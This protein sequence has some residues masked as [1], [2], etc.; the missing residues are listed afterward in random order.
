LPPLKIT[1]P[2]PGGLSY[3]SWLRTPS[4][5]Q[6]VEFIENRIVPTQDMLAFQGRW[7]YFN[8]AVAIPQNDFWQFTAVCPPDE[9]WRI[10]HI[11]VEFTTDANL[12]CSILIQSNF[13][14]AANSLTRVAFHEVENGSQQ[15]LYPTWNELST[16]A[17]NDTYNYIG[18]N[19]IILPN[20]SLI[21]RSSL[22]PDV[23]GATGAVTIRYEQVPPPTENPGLSAISPT[24]E[25]I[26]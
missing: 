7:F 18:K 21:L 19:F 6:P 22:M 15:C 24:I 17:R 5:F 25:A 3:L 26:T 1:T 13:L 12:D 10:S 14:D 16:S 11:I 23:G 8:G 9:S 2:E 4:K 20:E